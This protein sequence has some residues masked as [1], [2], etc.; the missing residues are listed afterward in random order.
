MGTEEQS[1]V[2]TLEISTVLTKP[3]S[4]VL[5]FLIKIKKL[6]V[7]VCLCVNMSYIYRCPQRPEED[8]RSPGAGAICSRELSDGAGNETQVVPLHNQQVLLTADP[9]LRPHVYFFHV[10]RTHST[11]EPHP[12][13][14]KVGL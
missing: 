12:H 6:Y 2:L 9:C 1:Q 13:T 7:C 8:I 10:L 11:T 4:Q 5:V 3:S 14:S